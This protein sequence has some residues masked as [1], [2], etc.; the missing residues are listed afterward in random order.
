MYNAKF[1]QDTFN[2][3]LIYQE[4]YFSG[5]GNFFPWFSLKFQVFVD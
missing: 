3:K 4:F 5:K 1:M 2:I